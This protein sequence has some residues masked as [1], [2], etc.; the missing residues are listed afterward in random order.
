VNKFM[1]GAD[2]YKKDLLA[3]RFLSINPI[4]DPWVFVILRPSVLRAI[5]SV[6]CCRMS[7]K[8]QD[9]KETSPAAKSK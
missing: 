7:L 5:R 4:I 3:L 1:Q 6:L 8:T 9:N 2:D